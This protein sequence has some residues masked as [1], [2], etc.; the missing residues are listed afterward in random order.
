MLHYRTRESESRG[1]NDQS[2][3]PSLLYPASPPTFLS[4]SILSPPVVQRI[5]QI[6]ST[7]LF[8]FRE[9]PQFERDVYLCIR[10]PL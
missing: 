4:S 8:G 1:E 3:R 7:N 9:N 5:N 2:M 10:F 6:A